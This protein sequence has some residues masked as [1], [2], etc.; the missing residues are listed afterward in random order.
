MT[1]AISWPSFAKFAERILG[2]ILN[3]LSI[4]LV[5]PNES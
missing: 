4:F 3:V 5:I 2:A 1:S